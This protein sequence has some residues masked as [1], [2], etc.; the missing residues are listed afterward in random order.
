M[1]YKIKFS[2]KATDQVAL[3]NSKDKQLLK[4]C[5]KLCEECKQF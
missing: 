5:I 3:L 2:N 1:I 4:K